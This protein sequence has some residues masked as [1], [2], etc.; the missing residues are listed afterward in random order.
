MGV[1]TRMVNKKV[2][3]LVVATMLIM[4]GVTASSEQTNDEKAKIAERFAS[5]IFDE[6]YWAKQQ[7]SALSY[8]SNDFIEGLVDPLD[9]LASSLGINT[10]SDAAT[11]IKQ[12][13]TMG[14]VIQAADYAMLFQL[15]RSSTAGYD[16][17]T[18]FKN[19]AKQIRNDEDVSGKAREIK[20]NLMKLKN[21]IDQCSDAN[22]ISSMWGGAKKAKDSAKKAVDGAIKYL[23]GLTK[24]SLF[25]KAGWNQISSP[26]TEGIDL[27]T[28]E[29]YCTVQGSKNKKLWKWDTLSGA[30]L[31][32]NKVEPFAGYWISVTNDCTVSLSGT[33]SIFRNLQ[34]YQGWNMISA[35]GKLNDVLGTCEKDIKLWYWD[36]GGW[37]NPTSLQI[38]KG[39]WIWTDTDCVLS[40]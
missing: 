36:S 21:D 27:S 40:R 2:I 5:T 13:V 30:W 32:P 20:S 12:F 15:C 1:V 23:D 37:T 14:S 24:T 26:I 39:Y 25:L 19:L 28:I 11:A 4:Q 17:K 22:L 34:L 6:G 18:E 10:Y 7:T 31:N 9:I 35:N 29:Q 8:F 16:F 38:D 33:L 3:A